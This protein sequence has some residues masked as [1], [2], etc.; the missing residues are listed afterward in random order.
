MSGS[1][2]NLVSSFTVKERKALIDYE[3]TSLSIR[4]QTQ[5][6]DI[7][8]SS[9]YYQPVKPSIQDLEYKTAIDRIY[10]KSPFFGSRRIALALSEEY[11]YTIN[12]KAV[13]RHMLEM[14]I[15]AI[16]KTKN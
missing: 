8:R 5:L 6:L 3:D 1:K 7:N 15:E 16:S 13:Q 11:G 14:G 2:K 12:R 10:T 4:Q 9:L